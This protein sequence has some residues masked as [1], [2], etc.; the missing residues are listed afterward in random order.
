NYPGING[1]GFAV[2]VKKTDSL[3]FVRRLQRDNM[4][5]FGI[6]GLKQVPQATD[7]FVVKYI[8][9]QYRNRQ[10]L[11]FDMGSEPKRRKAMEEARDNGQ[12]IVSGKV[13]LVQDQYKTP[14]FNIY[15]P[16]YKAGGD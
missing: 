16:V 15:V 7:Y 2:P 8:E 10:A 11:G 13:Q 3:A 9:P 4:P 5:W 12:P 6:T 14:G 1:L